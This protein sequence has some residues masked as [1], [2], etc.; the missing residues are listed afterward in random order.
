MPDR[1]IFLFKWAKCMC[2]LTSKCH[3][4]LAAWPQNC[5]K[6]RFAAAHDVRV[7][8]STRIRPCKICTKLCTRLAREGIGQPEACRAR[9]DP[10]ALQR[11]EDPWQSDER[12]QQCQGGPSSTATPGRSLAARQRGELTHTSNHHLASCSMA[13]SLSAWDSMSHSQ[14]GLRPQL[15][16]AHFSSHKCLQPETTASGLPKRA[17]RR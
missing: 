6:L 17:A 3:L 14:Q 2:N 15:Q 9:D 7:T 10:P 8:P 11:Q 4:I 12:A 16:A 13:C 5:P 1:H